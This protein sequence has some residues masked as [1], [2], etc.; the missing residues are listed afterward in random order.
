MFLKMKESGKKKTN[1]T[2]KYFKTL[3]ISLCFLIFLPILAVWRTVYRIYLI[4]KLTFYDPND[5]KLRKEVDEINKIIN[6]L[7]RGFAGILFLYILLVDTLEMSLSVPII[8]SKQTTANQIQID[9]RLF[10]KSEY[11]NETIFENIKS[12]STEDENSILTFLKDSCDSTFLGNSSKY[13]FLVNEDRTWYYIQD[14]FF[15]VG[16]LLTV[17]SRFL[18]LIITMVIFSYQTSRIKLTL[19]LVLDVLYRWTVICTV[20]FLN[21]TIGACLIG[22][23]S[24]LYLCNVCLHEDNLEDAVYD[25]IGSFSSPLPTK[26]DKHAIM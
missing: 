18:P 4:L 2:S 16:Y 1:R 25:W 13:L 24:S 15:L 22:V 26:F 20:M 23:L 5:I 3:L 6:V 11:L 14:E 12:N 17:M 8:C 21:K 19:H 7:E 9:K 10:M